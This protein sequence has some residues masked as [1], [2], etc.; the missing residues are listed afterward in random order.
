MYKLKLDDVKPGIM[1]YIQRL[2]FFFLATIGH[3][4][5]LFILRVSLPPRSK[6]AAETAS[7]HTITL[8]SLEI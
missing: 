1:G 3:F 5:P 8:E 4:W 2:P 7:P 6:K